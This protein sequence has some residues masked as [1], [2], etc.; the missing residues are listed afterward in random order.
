[1]KISRPSFQWKKDEFY[2]TDTGKKVKNEAKMNIAV[3]M[4]YITEGLGQKL[5]MLHVKFKTK[6]TA[7]YEICVLL[8][9]L[10]VK[11]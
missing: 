6:T 1:M 9:V 2:L 3:A 11:F 4:T 8:K 10:Y 5:S 7:E